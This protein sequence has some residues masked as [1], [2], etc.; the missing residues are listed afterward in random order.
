MA[1]TTHPD[2]GPTTEAL[3]VAAAF[4]TAIKDRT[5]LITGINK[6]GI[7][8]TTAEALASQSPRLLILAGRSTTKIQECIDSL[9]AQYPDVSYRPLQ[10][11]L[12]SQQYVRTAATEVLN[13]SDVPKIDLLI[14]NAGIMNIP[15][16]TL[17]PDGIELHLATNHLG[18]FLLTNL[19]MPKILAA[20]ADSTT[21]P[22]NS[23]R[24]INLSSLATYVSPLRTTDPNITTP[25]SSLPDNERPNL[26]MM[27]NADLDVNDSMTYI[28]M[29]AYGQSKTAN[30]LFTVGLNERL[31]EH[32]VVSIALH[33]GEMRTELA[34][35]TDQE[36]YESVHKKQLKMGLMGY[37]SLGQ[38]A[39]TT[40]VAACDPELSVG[41]EGEGKTSFLSDCQVATKPPAPGYAVDK[42]IAGKLWEM[43]EGWV[44][45]K[46]EW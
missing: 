44:G 34:R 27:R 19:L 33:P 38:G 18:H 16:Q 29:A 10:V 21:S 31:S 1:S 22:A 35:S 17:S 37:K 42:E 25:I 14:N 9:K 11:D 46:F 23:T 6:L 26:A 13:W 3:T 20:A 4:P 45:E 5:I 8:Y 40:L 2:F 12:S 43:S 7:G 41:G 32:G 24:I 36:W 28:P 39:A 30:I 15:T